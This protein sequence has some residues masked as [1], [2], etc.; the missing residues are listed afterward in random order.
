MPSPVVIRKR[1]S[2]V[3][4]HIRSDGLIERG[5]EPSV[6]EHAQLP[7]KAA[8]LD[9]AVIGRRIDRKSTRLNSSHE[10]S[11]YAVCCLKKTVH[12]AEVPR[13]TALA[14]DVRRPRQH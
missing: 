12:G 14:S 1:A 6:L 11:A 5:A 3:R 10:W 7:R 8:T 4:E 13:P 9:S 2:D